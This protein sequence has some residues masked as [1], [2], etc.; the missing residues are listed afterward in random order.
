M[1]KEQEQFLM[2][3]ADKGLAEQKEAENRNKQ[4]EVE[5]Q[6]NSLREAK[7][8]ELEAQAQDLIETGLQEFE[9]TV[10][11]GIKAN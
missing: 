6:V 10:A 5:T 9:D 2:D 7:K 4:I 1:T 11:S 8:A 3:F